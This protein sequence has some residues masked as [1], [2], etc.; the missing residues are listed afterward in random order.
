MTAT[1]RA[2]VKLGEVVAPDA[3]RLPRHPV[4]PGCGPPAPRGERPGSSRPSAP[5][6]RRTVAVETYTRSSR[7]ARA[8]SLRCERSTG[9]QSSN[10]AR[11]AARSSS[12]SP[13][14]AP[15]LAGKSA[16]RLASRRARHSAARSGSRPRAAG[17][18][19]R[20][21]PRSTTSSPSASSPAFAGASTRVGTG[22]AVSPNALFLGQVQRHRLLG[23]RRPQPLD[24]VLGDGLRRGVLP[25]HPPAGPAPPLPT[26]PTRAGGPPCR[27]APR[28]SDPPR[29]GR[30]R[31]A[32]WPDRSTP[33]R[34]SRTSRS[35]TIAAASACPTCP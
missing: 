27:P 10:R 14:T 30:R 18:P 34:R 5:S 21:Q 9:A 4:R 11:I 19:A 7:E 15:P 28:W 20:D 29:S 31:P 12:S 32:E 8:A 16:S 2:R 22:P 26:R 3:V 13:C 33:T 6:T 35:A 1:G 17:T 24:L 25:G 23:H